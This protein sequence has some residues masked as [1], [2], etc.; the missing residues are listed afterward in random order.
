MPCPHPPL[1]TTSLSQRLVAKTY[2]SVPDVSFLAIG[3]H[4]TCMLGKP[5][6]HRVNVPRSNPQPVLNGEL[7][8]KSFIFLSFHWDILIYIQPS[9]PEFPSRTEFQRQLAAVT[10]LTG[11]LSF[12][13]SL[14]KYL[15]RF[16]ANNSLIHYQIRT[17]VSGS[18][19]G[20]PKP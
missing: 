4:S 5:E 7:G 1:S 8:V 13:V 18:A 9:L 17:L 11:F 10:T 3:I 14:P 2:S 16:Y 12:T 6:C 20:E 15:P 19:S